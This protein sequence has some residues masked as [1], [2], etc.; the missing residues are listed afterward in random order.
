[1]IEVKDR[2]PTYPGRVRLV[3][4]EGQS[5]TYDMVRADEPIEPGT[6]INKVL[7]E[8][9]RGDFAAINQNVAN[10][11]SAHAKIGTLAS[12]P[13][14]TEFGLYENGVFTPFIKVTG[15][16]NGN[17]Q[18]A[19]MRKH[20]YKWDYLNDPGAGSRY[21]DG[22][23]DRWLNGAYLSL[24]EPAVQEAI[25][26]QSIPCVVG[27]G[28][29]EMEFITRKVFIASAAEYGIVNDDVYG[30]EGVPMGYFVYDPSRRTALYNGV[31]SHHWT[32]SFVKDWTERGVMISEGGYDANSYVDEN[33]SGIR[34]VFV[35]PFDFEVTVSDSG[36]MATAEVI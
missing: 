10:I 4:V 5:N 17:G 27:N 9:I 16:Y 11:I 13:N 25:M 18:N 26:E 14:G 35:L 34:P 19:V 6:P 12:L 32:R 36:E 28:S 29:E 33:Q 30:P 22:R 2:I 24:L 31:L 21:A 23:T 8:S 1:M 3:P 20:I 15:D 7:F